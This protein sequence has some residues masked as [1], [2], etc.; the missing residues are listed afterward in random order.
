MPKAEL[1]RRVQ[2]CIAVG[3]SFP[4]FLDSHCQIEDKDAGTAIPFKLWPEQRRI[5]PVLLTAPRLISIKARQLGITWLCAALS[6]WLCITRPLQLVVVISAKEDWAVEFMERC[7]FILARLPEWMVPQCSRDNSQVLTFQHKDGLVSEIKSLATTPEGAQS[8]TPTLLILD[9][10]AR[11]RHIRSIYA[12][13]KPGIDAGGGRI[14][15]ISNSIKDGVG[16]GFTRDLYVKSMKGENDFQRLFLSWTARP[17]RPADF[18]ERQVWEGMDPEDVVWHYPAT[19]DEAISAITGSYFGRALARHSTPTQG[20]V[21]D[22]VVDSEKQIIFTPE[23]RGILEVWRWPYHVLQAW[24]GRYWERRYAIGS[25]VSEGLGQSYS[26]AYVLD[27]QLDEIV[28]RL[29]S[30]RIDA[31]AWANLLNLL[32]LFYDRATVAV[33]RTGAGQTTVKRLSELCVPQYRR[34]RPGAVGGGMT[35][36]IGWHESQAAKHELAGDLKTWLTQTQGTVWCGR[37]L[38]ECSTFIRHESGKLD[39]EDDSKLADCVIAAGLTIQCS[40]QIGAPPVQIEPEPTGWL[41]RM[42]DGGDRPAQ[43]TL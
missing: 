13:S 23:Q 35:T 28:A 22:L 20:A 33:E 40:H 27:R 9:E 1:I 29:R 24:D 32:H 5:L 30:N 17:D 25:D 18:R 36:E 16:W 43:V 3:R 15:L 39:K 34:I 12:S 4:H 26:V 2:E 42:R 31:H 37:L 10:T 6:V 38:E 7:K 41:K 21:G 14:I 8:K 19:E 11:N